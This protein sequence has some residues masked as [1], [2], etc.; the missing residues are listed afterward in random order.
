M[1]QFQHQV[2]EIPFHR[3]RSERHPPSFWATIEIGGYDVGRCKAASFAGTNA[4]DHELTGL[5]LVNNKKHD[6]DWRGGSK[7]QGIIRIELGS[8]L[9]PAFSR[10]LEGIVRHF[11]C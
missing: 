6:A 5:I 10:R 9:T 7:R 8:W 3:F 11:G 1:E 2:G 4:F